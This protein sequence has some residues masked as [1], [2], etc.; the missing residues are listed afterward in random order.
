MQP[1][2]RSESKSIS[3]E[4]RSYQAARCEKCGAKMFPTTLLKPHLTL[5]R[6][7]QRWF[8]TELKK[9]QDTMT[10]MRDIA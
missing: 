3:I 6:R 9:L 7:K 5:H 10:R 4:S 8:M 2:L 1:A